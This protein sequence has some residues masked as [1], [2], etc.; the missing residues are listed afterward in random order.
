[1][2][3]FHLLITTYMLLIRYWNR[4]VMLRNIYYNVIHCNVNWMLILWLGEWE[5]LFLVY[6]MWLLQE[7]QGSAERGSGH[8]QHLRIWDSH[9][10]GIPLEGSWDSDWKPET[11]I[12]RFTAQ[13]EHMP[14]LP[15]VWGLH[16]IPDQEFWP[17]AGIFHML[18]TRK[19]QNDGSC[20]E[21][22]VTGLY[23]K[24]T[25]ALARESA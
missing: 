17:S 20:C 25:T 22:I 6:K 21:W 10:K 1:M 9:A 13:L 4:C 2:N 15:F 5:R 19:M 23:K 24:R 18:S 12:G 3:N 14:C 7:E 16:K 11:W 8:Q